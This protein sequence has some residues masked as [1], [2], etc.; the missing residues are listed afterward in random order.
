MKKIFKNKRVTIMGLGLLGGGVGAAKFFCKQG[1]KVLVTDLKT[2]IE[3][4]DSLRKLK[5]LSITYILGSHRQKDFIEADLIIRNPG[6]P[7]ESPYLK[8]AKENKVLIENDISVFFKLCQAPIVG[9]TGTKGKS[10]VATLIYLFLKKKY[11]NSVLAGNIGV[12]PLESLPEIKKTGIVVLELSSFELEELKESP[13]AAVITNILPDHLNRYKDI[14]EYIEAKKRIFLFQK[15]KDMLVLNYDDIYASSF[16][17][18]VPS[19]TYFYSRKTSPK[20]AASFKKFASFIKKG[21]IFFNGEEEAICAVEKIKIGGEHNISNILAAVSVAKLLKIPNQD[22]RRVLYRFKGVPNRQEFI[23]E[24]NGVKYFNDTTATMPEAS[25]AAIKTFKSKFPKSK[26]LLIAGGQDKNLD[27]KSMGRVIR[28]KVGVLLLLPG[29]SSEKI[30][31]ELGQK[32]N[33]INVSTMKQA[34]LE[35]SKNAK[36]GDIVILSPGAASFNLFNNEFDRGRKFKEAV[37]NLQSY[38]K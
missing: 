1:A 28:E 15:S 10:T 31:E 27:Y 5:G 16:V 24:V 20:D 38:G 2:K 8:I 3:L 22:I 34:V 17:K 18:E 37:F 21:E 9:V 23:R 32:R 14:K 35:A 7:K 13:K 6:V 25:I 11:K 36:E 26:L 4:A 19:L 29:T 33:I 30:K 12:T